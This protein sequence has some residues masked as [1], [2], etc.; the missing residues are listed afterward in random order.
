M[1]TG[2]KIR[3]IRKKLGMTQEELAHKIGYKSKTSITHIEQDRDKSLDIIQN[4]AKALNTS[5]PYLAGWELDPEK[6]RYLFD[7]IDEITDEQFETLL[8]VF[9]QLKNEKTKVR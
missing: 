6:K 7:N 5:A 3:M 8:S 2:Q 9:E 4:I 1:T